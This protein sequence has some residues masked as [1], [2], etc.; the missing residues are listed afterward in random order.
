VTALLWLPAARRVP[1]PR[2]FPW[3]NGAPTKGCLHTTEGATQPDYQGWTEMPHAEVIPKPG[4]GVD[5]EQYLPFDQ[6][7]FSLEHPTGTAPTNGAHVFQFELRGTCVATGPGYHW[8][9]ADDAVLLDL[10]RKVI[11]PVSAAYV[12]P[13]VTPPWQPYPAAYGPKGGTNTV[14]LSQAAFTGW[15]GWLGHQ[16]AASNVHGDPGAFPWARMMTLAHP[17]TPDRPAAV[18]YVHGVSR[19]GRADHGPD[20]SVAVIQR[21][22]GAHVDGEYGRQTVIGVENFQA[23]RHLTVDGVCGPQTVRRFGPGVVYLPT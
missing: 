11:Q 14:R 5:V 10:F 20:R 18:E 12:I 19:Y 21:H 4:V 22:V 1:H 17:V 6:G 9:T 7:S 3:Q 15:H 16:H 23:R 8:P 13:L 2:S